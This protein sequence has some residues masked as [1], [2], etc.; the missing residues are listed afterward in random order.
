MF[1]FV[2]LPANVVELV[3]SFTVVASFTAMFDRIPCLTIPDCC[4]TAPEKKNMKVGIFTQDALVHA[5][6]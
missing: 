4:V 1:L 3:I 2:T 5:C 6:E